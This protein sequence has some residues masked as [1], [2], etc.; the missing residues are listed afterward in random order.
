[1]LIDSLSVVAQGISDQ[2]CG[3]EPD[4]DHIVRLPNQTPAE[5]PR[6]SLAAVKLATG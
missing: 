1:M 5:M 3:Y 4:L 2:L 6:E